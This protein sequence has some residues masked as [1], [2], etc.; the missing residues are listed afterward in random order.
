MRPAPSPL[1]ADENIEGVLVRALRVLGQ[2]ILRGIDVHPAGTPDVAHFVTAASLGRVLLSHDADM[3]AIATR[4]QAESRF[5]A[6]LIFLPTRK[7]GD[8][9]AAIRAVRR[10]VARFPEVPPANRIFFA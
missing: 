1:Y 9:R 4:W 2:D 7:Y 3:L 10:C 8:T 5:F 6:G